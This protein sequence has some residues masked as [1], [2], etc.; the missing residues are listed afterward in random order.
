MLRAGAD[1]ERAS[2]SRRSARTDFPGSG[3]SRLHPNA[4]SST[5][6]VRSPPGI[7]T[8]TSSPTCL[9]MSERASGLVMLMLPLARSASSAPR[10][11]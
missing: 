6:Y 9:P 5:S 3:T 1:A 8:F 4:M 7:R 10:I 11:R 2:E